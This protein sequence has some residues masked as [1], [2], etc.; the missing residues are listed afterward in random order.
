[1]FKATVISRPIDED[2]GSLYLKGVGVGLVI[3]WVTSA[4]AYLVVSKR[5]KPNIKT[6][7]PV[8]TL[9]ILFELVLSVIFMILSVVLP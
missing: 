2:M 8:S 6:T 9:L 4:L 3:A 7:L 5:G 1:M